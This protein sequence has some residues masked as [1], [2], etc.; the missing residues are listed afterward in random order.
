MSEDDVPPGLWSAISRTLEVGVVVSSV[1]LLVGIGLLLAAGGGSIHA[2]GGRV[3]LASLPGDLSGANG[4]GL[5]LLGVLVLV[6]TPL[7]R[8]VLSLGVFAR[9]GDLTFASLTLFVLVVLVLG[10]VLGVIP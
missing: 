5:L 9:A 4:H 8:V 10:L 2:A 7:A 3:S 6:F 1:L